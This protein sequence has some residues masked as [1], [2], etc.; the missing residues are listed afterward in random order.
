MQRGN[1]PD[2][3]LEPVCFNLRQRFEA[4][5][6]LLH[7][8]SREA[9]AQRFRIAK[10]RRQ[11]IGD[12]F[13]SPDF[14]FK[15]NL[16]G[17]QRGGGGKP[18]QHCN[19]LSNGD[20]VVVSTKAFDHLQIVRLH[21]PTSARRIAVRHCD[22]PLGIEIACVEKRFGDVRRPPHAGK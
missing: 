21:P 17:D 22:P 20:L 6:E 9:G 19:R 16:L 13:R 8:I 7:I 3:F 5:K 2:H 15:E 1:E 14:G 12:L 4:L 10:M 18:V 11:L